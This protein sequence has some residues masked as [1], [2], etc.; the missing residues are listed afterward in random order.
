MMSIGIP[1]R[2]K[3]VKIEKDPSGGTEC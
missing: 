3:N 1:Y 2:K